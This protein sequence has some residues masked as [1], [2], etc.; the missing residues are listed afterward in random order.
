MAGSA[1]VE[2]LVALVLIAIAG[3]VVA[4][5]SVAG[6]RATRRA[7]T[8]TRTTALATRELAALTNRAAVAEGAETMLTVPGFADPVT[9]TTEVRRDAAVVALAVRVDAGR[10]AEHVALTTR[11]LVEE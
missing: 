11:R 9:C 5:A 2:A 6:L 3:M 7:A 8:L 1:L 4:S 10:P